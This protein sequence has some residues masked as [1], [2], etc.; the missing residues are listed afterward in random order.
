MRLPQENERVDPS[1]APESVVEAFRVAGRT[2]PSGRC[3]RAAIGRVLRVDT[4][5]ETPVDRMFD[6][7]EWILTSGHVR[8]RAF[9]THGIGTVADPDGRRRRLEGDRRGCARKIELDSNRRSRR[10][11]VVKVRRQCQNCR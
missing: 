6:K 5:D 10:V 4:F 9:S 8:L 1:L 2:S 11:D 3:R 7:A